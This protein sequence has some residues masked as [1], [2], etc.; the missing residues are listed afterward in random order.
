MA[1]N[2]NANRDN[3]YF[4]PLG[5]SNEIGMNLNLYHLDGKW[6][7]IDMGIGFV[8]DHFPGIEIMV[9][10]I[11]FL[12]SQRENIVGMVITHA[13][14]DHLGAVPYLWDE[15]QCPVY[16]TK[17]TAAVLRRKLDSNSIFPRKIPVTEV[18][19]GSEFKVGDF[20]L[21]LIPLTHSIPEMQAVAVKTRHGTVMHT[22]DWKLD[23]D[24]LVGPVSDEATLKRYGDAGVLAM[25]CDSTNVFVEGESGSE[26][27]VRIALTEAVAKQKGKVFV[28]SF[29][30]NIARVESVIYAAKA[31]GRSVVLAGRSLWRIV[32]SAQESGYLLDVP[33]LI[34][35]KQASK[36]P[37]SKLLVLCTGCQG[38]PRAA[39]TKIVSHTHPSIRIAAE[40]TVFFSSRVIPGNETRVR[41]ITNQLVKQGVNIITDR[42]A[43]I[44]VSGHPAR[45]ELK[46]MYDLVRPQI[47]IPVHGEAAH[48]R[49]HSLF[50]SSLGIAETVEPYN[51]AIVLLK[52]GEARVVDTVESGYLGLDGNTL[53]PLS[54]PIIKIR[55]RLKES[56]CVM[57]SI[58]LGK[59][60]G[61]VTAPEITAPGCLDPYEDETLRHAL[62]QEVLD[63]F[64]KLPPR[65]KL[66]MVK[67]KI[68]NNL[69]KR[70]M[71]ELGKTPMI[72]ILIHQV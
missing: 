40:D 53:I 28:A 67:E 38:E 42:D 41:W 39:L 14:E 64:Q 48:I 12:V 49:E 10:D 29:A 6:L 37:A 58:V 25:V 18:E 69:R 51:G 21:D 65:G 30:S 72:E 62:E 13:H 32:E 70:I 27:D 59:D 19:I 71:D 35:E 43:F 66:Q 33:E 61:M 68:R 56:G 3:F 26:S 45:G 60:G 4:V 50:A 23:K 55:R 20:T 22:G 47:A 31:C 7:I 15:L 17:F 63:T 2:F 52:A 34:S 9:P 54:S 8:D 44:H 36:L 46:R 57:V 24:P 11:D 1:F 5:G 16:A